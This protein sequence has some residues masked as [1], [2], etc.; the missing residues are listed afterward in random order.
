VARLAEELSRE[1]NDAVEK[2]LTL[3]AGKGEEGNREA[4]SDG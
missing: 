2:G 1:A 4:G 3:A